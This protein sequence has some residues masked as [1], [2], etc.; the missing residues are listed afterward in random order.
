MRRAMGM[1]AA[2]VLLFGGVRTAEAG[3]VTYTSQSAFNSATNNDTTVN[4]EGLVP[5]NL[6]PDDNFVQYDTPPG[7]TV[8]GVNF[9]IN[10][11][12][13][14][15][16]LYVV[17]DGYYFPNAVLTSQQSTTAEN[18]LIITLP[19]AATAIGFD[20]GTF[21]GMTITV[22]FSS[23]DTATIT[24]TTSPPTFLNTINFI[25]F[26]STEAITSLELDQSTESTPTTPEDQINLQDFE[27]GTA[28]VP[29]PSS[30]TLL[31]TAGISLA[32]FCWRRKRLAAPN[33]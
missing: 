10:T 12:N 32:A 16:N 20:L 6:P 17:G 18:S 11:A 1:T 4:F 23:G 30:L 26:T 28:A 3:L 14:D 29:E 13:S 33:R 25:G 7:V 24:P 8:G 5:A 31:G 21:Y 27:F 15:G 22:T 9:D 2:L 19:Q